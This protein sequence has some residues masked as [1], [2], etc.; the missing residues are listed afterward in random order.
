MLLSADEFRSIHLG[1]YIKTGRGSTA[2]AVSSNNLMAQELPSSVDWRTKGV[3][4][5][6]KNQVSN[7]LIKFVKKI[8]EYD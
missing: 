6:I 7:F 3:I 8:F 4:S 1:G 2:G 5:D